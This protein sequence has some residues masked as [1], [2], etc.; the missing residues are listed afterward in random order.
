MDL[1]WGERPQAVPRAESCHLVQ[2]GL[3]GLGRKKGE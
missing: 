1:R 3:Q 2:E